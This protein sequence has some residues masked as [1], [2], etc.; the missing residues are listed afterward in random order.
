MQVS[1]NK[2][3]GDVWCNLINLNLAH[4]HF[5]NMEGVYIIWH[6]GSNPA[7]VYVGQGA[8]ADRLQAH[9]INP[10]I[11]AYSS[12]GLF[13]TWAS[14]NAASRSGVERYLADR[15]NPKVGAAHPQI[16]PIAVNLPW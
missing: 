10:E 7:T 5:Q 1:W 11:L 2:C 6:G 4:S 15:L 16:A 12:H 14:V 13:V 8:I 9:R 3:T